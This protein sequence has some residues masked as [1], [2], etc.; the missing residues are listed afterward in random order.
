MIFKVNCN[1]EA[2]K[3]VNYLCFIKH[4]ARAG[5]EYCPT[6]RASAQQTEKVFWL[7]IC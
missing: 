5:D 7:C 4:S 1:N 6:R 2:Q 3:V